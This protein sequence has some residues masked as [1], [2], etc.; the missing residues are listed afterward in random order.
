MRITITDQFVKRATTAGRASPIFRDAEVIGFGVQVRSSARKSFTLDYTFEGRRRR[1]YIGDYP[2][3]S[4]A[5]ARDEAKRIKREVDRGIDPLRVRDERAAAPTVSD[6]AQRFLTEHVVRLAT[7]VG[8]DVTS[9]IRTFVIPA[10]SARKAADIR[11]SDVDALLAEIARGRARP[12]KAKT[13][14]RRGALLKGARPTPVRANRVGAVIRKMFALAVRWG[15]RADN[16]ASSFI[17]NPEQH[18]ERFLDRK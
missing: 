16:P 1:V 6:L 4:V 5:A 15:M 11:P 8:P 12:H 14:H 9:M 3:W 17:R 7:S 13:K 10:W 18:R 2:D